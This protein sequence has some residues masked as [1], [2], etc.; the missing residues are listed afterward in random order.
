MKLLLVEDNLALV[1]TLLNFLTEQGFECTHTADANEALHQL[2]T[3]IFDAIILDINLGESSGYTVIKKCRQNKNAIPI[4]VISSLSEID[5]RIKGLNQGA[6]DYL[7]KPFDNNELLAR[8]Q[9]LLRRA[10]GLNKN[11][12]SHKDLL[13]D[14]D[15]GLAHRENKKIPLRKK[16]FLMLEYL[17]LNKGVILTRFQILDRVW[18]TESDIDSNKIDVHIKNLRK[19]IDLPFEEGYIKTVRG[20]GYVLR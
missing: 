11:Q 16:E 17:L 10:T 9:A 12:I 5:H 18:G 2:D 15:S 6:D 3:P 7:T 20:V 14:L 1:N 13:L 8:L 4:L 19:Q